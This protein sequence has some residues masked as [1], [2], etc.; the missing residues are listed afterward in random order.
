MRST[1]ACGDQRSGRAG[2]GLALTSNKKMAVGSVLA[3]I[4]AVGIVLAVILDWSEVCWPWDFLIGF[5]FGVVAGI[6]AALALFGLIERGR[7]AG[8]HS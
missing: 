8:P 3:L 6:G 7:D 5:L 1:G 2:G 4:G